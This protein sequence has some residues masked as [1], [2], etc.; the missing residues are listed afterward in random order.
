MKTGSIG[1]DQ[2]THSH[3]ALSPDGKI[4]IFN[5]GS[6]RKPPQAMLARV[7]LDMY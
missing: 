5:S 2:E 1:V 7:T 3:P 4:V 6:P